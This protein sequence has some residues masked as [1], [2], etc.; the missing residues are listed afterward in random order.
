MLG[1]IRDQQVLREIDLHAMALS[2]GYGWEQVQEPVQNV[3]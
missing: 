1:V 2:N 3:N